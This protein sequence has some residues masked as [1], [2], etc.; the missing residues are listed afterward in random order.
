M[1]KNKDLSQLNVVMYVRKSSESED[2]QVQSI[3][4]QK[5]RTR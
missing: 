1:N 5:I 2:R 4:D 3:A